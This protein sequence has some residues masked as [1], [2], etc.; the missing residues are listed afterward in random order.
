MNSCFTCGGKGY[1]YIRMLNN[2]P[3]RKKRKQPCPNCSGINKK[4]G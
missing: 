1:Y 3:L 4:D 2:K